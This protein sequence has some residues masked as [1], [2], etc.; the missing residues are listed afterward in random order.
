M[1]G[2]RERNKEEAAPAAHMIQ[3]RWCY[4]APIKKL[5]LHWQWR[6]LQPLFSPPPVPVCVSPQPLNKANQLTSFKPEQDKI[7]LQFVLNVLMHDTKRF[8]LSVKCCLK[9]EKSCGQG[10]GGNDKMDGCY[11]RSM[12]KNDLIPRR[13]GQTPTVNTIQYCR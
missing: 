7:L 12:I 13:W 3:L 9:Y 1:E 4:R 8:L 2:E 5:P 11:R 10:R 6:L